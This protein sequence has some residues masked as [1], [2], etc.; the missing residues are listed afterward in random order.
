[1]TKKLIILKSI[2]INT[3]LN[4]LFFLVLSRAT[5]GEVGAS[6]WQFRTLNAPNYFSW[7]DDSTIGCVD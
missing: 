4:N 1:M 5:L 7:F 3:L 2:N 6:V